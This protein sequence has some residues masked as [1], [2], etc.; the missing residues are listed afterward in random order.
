M[1]NVLKIQV[2]K[3]MGWREATH[4]DGEGGVDTQVHS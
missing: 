1:Y 3:C 4:P 2:T